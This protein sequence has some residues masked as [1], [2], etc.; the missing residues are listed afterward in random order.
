MATLDD[1][2][3]DLVTKVEEKEAEIKEMNDAE[4]KLTQQRIKIKEESA[5]SMDELTQLKMKITPL[6]SQLKE[7]LGDIEE[8]F[9]TKKIPCS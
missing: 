7:I 3:S 9:K 5:K 8:V 4:Y 1:E 6:E 2:Q